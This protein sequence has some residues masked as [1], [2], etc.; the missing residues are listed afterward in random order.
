MSVPSSRNA[1]INGNA[2]QRDGG[3]RYREREERPRAGTVSRFAYGTGY[4]VRER[5]KIALEGFGGTSLRSA[6]VI[7]VLS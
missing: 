7:P 6:I 5:S 3:I 4:S 1:R 2:R